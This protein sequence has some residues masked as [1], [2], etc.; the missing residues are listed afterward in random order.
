MYPDAEI[1]AALRCETGQ[2]VVDVPG[3]VLFAMRE[4]AVFVPLAAPT[5]Q[6]EAL[7]FFSNSARRRIAGLLQLRIG[8]CTG[9]GPMPAKLVLP[10]E[11]RDWFDAN[12][13]AAALYCGSS[14]PLQKVSI[15]LP[16]REEEGIAHV[17]KIALRPA[18]DEPIAREAQCLASLADTGADVRRHVP[19]LVADGALPSGRRYVATTASNGRRGSATLQ[20]D[21]LHFLKS[22]ARATRTD[23]SWEDGDALAHT[24]ERLRALGAQALGAEVFGLLEQALQVS[25]A[26][27]RGKR[28]PHTLMHGD[29]TR[30][31]IRQ[32]D[33]GFV[34][35]DWEY[36]RTRSNPI[37]DALHYRLSRRGS[38]SANWTLQRAIADASKFVDLAFD[39]WRP[40]RAD[41]V[42]LALHA[43]VDTVILYA[44]ADG[45]LDTRSFV[46][47][48]YL[49]LIDARQSWMQRDV[50]AATTG[51]R[52]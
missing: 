21:Y 36:S 27:L 33:A 13:E 1:A 20:D 17:V 34:A 6:A 52:G 4:R 30:F 14:G 5:R 43:L 51:N 38:I 3:K 45:R 19:A 49:D 9:F 25:A 28:I 8:R 11:W 10:A 26:Q 16:A 22:L 48:R 7:A 31:N 29:F 18:A 50:G 42:A 47:T 40:T 32:H 37:A 46:V 15:L 41:L 24:R 44:T 2:A 23:M 12:L 39:D 35:F